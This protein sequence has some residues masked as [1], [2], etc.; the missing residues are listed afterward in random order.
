MGKVAVAVGAIAA[1]IGIAA[2]IGQGWI[3]QYLFDRTVEKVAGQDSTVSYPDGIHAY[4]CGSGSPLPDAERAGPCIAVLAGRE[5]FIFDAGSGSIRK[6]QR[7]GFPMD[8]LEAA[9]LTHLH[10]DHIDGFGELML[11]AW[12]A[13][14]RDEPLPVYGPPGTDKVVEGFMQAYAIDRGY[15]I[16]H[17]GPEVA[18]P[19]G[20]GGAVHL[21]DPPRTGAIAYDAAGVIIRVLPVDHSPVDYAFAY[22]IEYGGRVL[23][24]SGDTKQS[25]E[26]ASFA[27]G[28]DVLFH[29]ALNPQ[30]VGKIGST[31]A[32][33][34]DSDGSKIMADIPDYHTTPA[35]AAEVA[36]QSGVRALVLYHLVPAPPVRSVKRAFLGNAPDLFDGDLR[37]GDDGLLVSLPAKG[38]AIEFTD[39]L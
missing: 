31:L 21:L 38:K 4:L 37:I 29:E 7:M 24:I 23:V 3:G 18:R 11:Q 32:E 19:G 2:W 6:L 35:Q 8:R 36:N 5:A 12:M 39:L 27:K 16:T 17:H 25:A 22:R 30:M 10:S 13:G 1:L 26:L 9:F 33:H 20:F 28:A 34:G 14:G 15:R